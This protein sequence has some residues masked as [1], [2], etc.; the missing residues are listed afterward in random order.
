MDKRPRGFIIRFVILHVVTY[1]VVGFA[2][3]TLQNY[4]EAFAVMQEFKLY[5]PT[6]DPIVMAAIPLQILRGGF[7]ALPFVPFHNTF[8]RK[9]YGWLLLFGLVYGLTA[10]GAPNFFA[11]LF[12]DIAARKP[13]AEFLIGPIEITVQ[14]SLFSI[15]LFW[16]GR[17]RMKKSVP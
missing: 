3:Y 7:L 10:L 11:G 16:W 8:A 12:Q 2:L 4:E 13:L 14:M 17:G 6:D 15:L 5:R 9:S 1:A